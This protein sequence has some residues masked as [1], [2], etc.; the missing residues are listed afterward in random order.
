M[1]PE[2]AARSVGPNWNG[3]AK[4]ADFD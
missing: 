2:G 1:T 3:D 4:R